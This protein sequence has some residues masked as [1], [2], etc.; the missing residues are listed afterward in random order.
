MTQRFYQ[1]VGYRGHFKP[2]YWRPYLDF[3][4]KHEFAQEPYAVDAIA[5][6]KSG[7]WCRTDSQG[8]EVPPFIELVMGVRPH[9]AISLLIPENDFDSH[10]K[11]AM[12]WTH[13]SHS[14]P[15]P[16]PTTMYASLSPIRFG[17]AKELA[18]MLKDL[19][20]VKAGARE[21]DDSK[22]NKYLKEG[23]IKPERGRFEQARLL[24]HILYAG[25]AELP[26]IYGLPALSPTI[27]IVYFALTHWIDPKT[28]DP[29]AKEDLDI[30]DFGWYEPGTGTTKHY[31]I[32]ELSILSKVGKVDFIHGESTVIAESQIPNALRSLFSGTKPVILVTHDWARTSRFLSS[33]DIETDST[34]WHNG[35]GTLLG[36][37]RPREH[38]LGRQTANRHQSINSR[39]SSHP[40][41]V[42][43]SPKDE[44][45][46]GVKS[47]DGKLG[48]AFSHGKR[49][50]DPRS[51]S[52]R[53]RTRPLERQD[54]H[55]RPI[56]RPDEDEENEGIEHP[57]PI[58]AVHIIDIRELFIALA[59]THRSFILYPS[60]ANRLGLEVEGW[61]AGNWARQFSTALGLLIGQSPIHQRIEELRRTPSVAP[62]VSV[63]KVPTVL[64]GIAGSGKD[65]AQPAWGDSS[66]EEDD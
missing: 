12:G 20:P 16:Y 32:E 63:T 45:E 2:Y 64:E 3:G 36:F 61:C 46:H 48:M 21:C 13:R 26:S 53:S 5:G 51:L 44:F 38:V 52:P 47:E 37:G 24:W 19:R 33:Q 58:P 54:R 15:D 17:S 30:L 14:C 59:P 28:Y 6:P 7:L 43:C 49:E 56:F 66:D 55:S 42:E 62:R 23:D 40:T 57:P 8:N 18:D 41:S 25:R 11:P 10:V 27:R 31:I 34:T 65:E 39:S 9:G 29:S 4:G 1:V 50:R 35:V 22:L 60:M